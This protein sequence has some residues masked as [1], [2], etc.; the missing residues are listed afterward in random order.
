MTISKTLAKVEHI[1]VVIQ[2][3]GCLY[4][5]VLYWSCHF[6]VVIQSPGWQWRFPYPSVASSA[7]FTPL[8]WVLVWVNGRGQSRFIHRLVRATSET[9]LAC[10]LR[11]LYDNQRALNIVQRLY[12]LSHWGNN[13]HQREPAERCLKRPFAR[14]CERS[15][16]GHIP[17]PS[18]TAHFPTP[19]PRSVPAPQGPALRS[20]NFR[21]RSEVRSN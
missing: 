17:A 12:C 8:L 19:A 21:P 10:E 1:V 16:S 5:T 9:W 18:L 11:Q 6:V 14:A 15:V 4:W 2:S 13:I 3:P 7:S 20:S